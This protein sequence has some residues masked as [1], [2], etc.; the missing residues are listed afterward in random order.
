MVVSFNGD[1][2]DI[3]VIKS[4]IVQVEPIPKQEKTEGKEN[5]S[6][7]TGEQENVTNIVKTAVEALENKIK[8]YLSKEKK[9][10]DKRLET[11]KLEMQRTLEKQSDAKLDA[12]SLNLETSA[13]QKSNDLKLQ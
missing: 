2:I 13:L 3:F 10:T 6:K 11:F 4:E 8:N 7:A 1:R 9:E 12:M 5:N